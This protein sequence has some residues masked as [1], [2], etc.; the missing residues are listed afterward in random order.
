MASISLVERTNSD[1]SLTVTVRYRD[2]S[3]RQKKKS[4]REPTEA[5]SRRAG[6]DY[7]VR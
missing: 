7:A 6:K 5:K 1:G 2:A 4:F 3:R